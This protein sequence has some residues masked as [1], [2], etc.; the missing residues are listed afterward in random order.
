MSGLELNRQLGAHS[1]N[2]KIGISGLVTQILKAPVVLTSAGSA[3]LLTKQLVLDFCE[4]SP[5]GN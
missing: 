4:R 2:K 3:D 5:E 1:N